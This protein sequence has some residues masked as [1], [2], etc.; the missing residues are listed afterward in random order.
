[1]RGDSRFIPGRGG[2]VCLYL[3]LSEYGNGRLPFL[4]NFEAP[5]PRIDDWQKTLVNKER[6]SGVHRI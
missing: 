5:V 2:Y 3:Q 6:R 4:F 1:M